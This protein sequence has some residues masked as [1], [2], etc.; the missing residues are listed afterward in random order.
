MPQVKRVPGGG[1]PA[2]SC[3]VQGVVF[4]KNVAHKRMRTSIPQAGIMLLAGAL[5]WQPA[6]SKLQQFDT[7]L[8]E[9]GARA[10]VLGSVTEWQRQGLHATHPIPHVPLY[11]PRSWRRSEICAAAAPACVPAAA[12]VESLLLCEM[13][14]R[15]EL[16][17]PLCLGLQEQAYLQAA[18]ERIAS[19]NPDV[20]VV[21]RSVARYAQ[22]SLAEHANVPGAVR[23]PAVHANRRTL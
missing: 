11:F 15:S 12:V 7:L 8:N 6:E 13:G 17:C 22:V 14:A 5:E 20:L 1:D 4:R 2:A 21:E 10:L 9:V 18:V 16:P 3:V 23:P 19:F